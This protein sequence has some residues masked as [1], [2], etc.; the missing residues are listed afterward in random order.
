MNSGI[1]NIEFLNKRL[2][3]TSMYLIF[4]NAVGV[5]QLTGTAEWE[6]RDCVTLMENSMSSI[7]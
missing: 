6:E 2:L 1:A 7:Y 4:R 3:Q 5:Y